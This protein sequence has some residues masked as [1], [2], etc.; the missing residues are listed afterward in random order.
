MLLKVKVNARVMIA[1]NIDLYNRLI[2]S[3]IGIV[4][5]IS[6]N[7]NEVNTIYIAFDDVSAG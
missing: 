2:T 4:N 1:I 7:K 3:Q 6:I 5:Y